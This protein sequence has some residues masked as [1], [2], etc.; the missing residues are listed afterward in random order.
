MENKVQI[1]RVAAKALII[2]DQNKVL[3][4]RE[5]H[6]YEEGTNFGRYGL[7]GGR[8]EVGESFFDGLRREVR[9]ET[10]LEVQIEQ[11]I[12]VSE[13]FPVIKGVQNQIIGVFFIC[14]PLTQVITLSSAH[15]YYMWVDPYSLGDYYMIESDFQ[16]IKR[17]LTVKDVNTS[18]YVGKT[19][20]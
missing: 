17:A 6:A 7:P 3:I 12:F 15:D 4:L 5:S 14:R 2:N 18:Q 8:V 10:G 20:F 19:L 16:A 11:P 1:Q 13:W 9:E